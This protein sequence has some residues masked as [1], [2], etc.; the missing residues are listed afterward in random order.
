MFRKVIAPSIGEIELLDLLPIHKNDVIEQAAKF[1]VSSPRHAVVTLRRLLHYVKK[2]RMPC[3]VAAE[4]F[5]IPGYRPVKDMCAWTQPEIAQV[6]KILSADYSSDFGKRCSNQQRHAHKL[7]IKRT[8][9]LFELNLHSSIRLSEALS[10]NKSDINWNESELRI[11]D[12]KEKGTWKTV[13][14]H[15]AE[16][17]LHDYLSS[18]G[19]GGSALFATFDGKRLTRNGAGTTLKRLK[20]RAGL[21]DKMAQSMT[22]KACRS[23]FITH[24]LRSGLDPKTVQNLAHHKS[25]HTTLNYYMKVVKENLKPLHKEMFQKI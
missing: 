10:A 19:D 20:K 5:K 7:V 8:R 3:G 15:G 6:R 14:I 16:A 21:S 9:A 24:A 2:C 1:G 22:H 25:L 17:A 13:F 18:R 11:E 12:C 23:T 4:E